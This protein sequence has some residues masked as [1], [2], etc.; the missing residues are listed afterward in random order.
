[1]ALTA[2]SDFPVEVQGPRG[3]DLGISF[4]LHQLHCEDQA[5]S[6]LHA[7]GGLA[8]TVGTYNQVAAPGRPPVMA[9]ARI[10]RVAF[11]QNAR[12][13]TLLTHARAVAADT[14]RMVAGVD[15]GRHFLVPLVPLGVVFAW[16]I[17]MAT[18]SFCGR[19]EWRNSLMF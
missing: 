17:A 7:E 11:L 9:I 4:T 19:P 6:Q 8:L 13:C 3:G 18:A 16:R 10:A 14:G 15:E 5:V 12:P 2:V 1:M